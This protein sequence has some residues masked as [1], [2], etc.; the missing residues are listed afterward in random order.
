MASILIF[1]ENSVK[2]HE[3]EMCENTR[4][5]VQLFLGISSGFS[6]SQTHYVD[7]HGHF[8]LKKVEIICPTLS[9]YKPIYRSFLIF[10]YFIVKQKVKF[11]LLSYVKICF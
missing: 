2:K 4:I 10:F 8:T 9:A 11:Y 6:I 3:L 5:W 7:R 1:S